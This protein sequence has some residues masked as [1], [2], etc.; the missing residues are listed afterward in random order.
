VRTSKL[1]RSR[2]ARLLFG[3]AIVLMSTSAGVYGWST[4][5]STMLGARSWP[6]R[7]SN[8]RTTD[9][10]LRGKVHFDILSK[11]LADHRRGESPNDWLRELSESRASPDV[12]TQAHLLIGH[13]APD[14]VLADHRA[15][16]WRLEKQIDLGP[17]VLVF[18][19]GYQ[20]NACVHHL[21]ELNADLDRFR[22][23][24]A[25][26]VAISDDP[27]ELTRVQFERYGAFGFPVLSDPDHA[28]AGLFGVYH[29]AAENE[30]ARLQHGTFLLG[31]DGQVHWAQYGGTPFR[32]VKA[33]LYQLALLEGKLP[34]NVTT[35]LVDDGGA[36][37][38]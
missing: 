30:P 13:A 21:F 38:P 17:V 1:P 36:A 8:P 33:V 6:A 18:Y 32:D 12:E 3:L 31:R 26:I 9:G 23:L 37:P 22:A 28:V 15:Q 16:Q 29:D 24:G 14:F 19:L 10:H 5:R 4:T 27:P 7:A 35:P 20:C 2:L 25:Q 11:L 34:L